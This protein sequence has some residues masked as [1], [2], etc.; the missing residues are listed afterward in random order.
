M[1]SLKR[2]RRRRRLLDYCMYGL[3]VLKFGELVTFEPRCKSFYSCKFLW[4][5]MCR[6]GTYEV[7]FWR[8]LLRSPEGYLH[9]NFRVLALK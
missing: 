3:S 9:L 7:T 5:D 4:N 2:P 8:N 6:T 1:A